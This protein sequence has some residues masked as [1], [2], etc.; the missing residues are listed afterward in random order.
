MSKANPSNNSYFWHWSELVLQ[1]KEFT[2]FA[3]TSEDI[4]NLAHG[5]MLR[6]ALTKEILP[7]IDEVCDD[8]SCYS[9]PPPLQEF[10]GTQMLQSRMDSCRAEPWHSYWRLTWSCSSSSLTFLETAVK[11]PSEWPNSFCNPWKTRIQPWD[12]ALHQRH[13]V[14]FKTLWCSSIHAHTYARQPLYWEK[15]LTLTTC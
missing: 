4:N 15:R 2:H 14:S 6:E 9:T 10:E 3:C 5:L 1:I 11:L 7:L 13:L 8:S 12:R